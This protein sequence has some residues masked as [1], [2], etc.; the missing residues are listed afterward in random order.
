[1]NPKRLV[2]AGLF[3]VSIATGAVVFAQDSKTDLKM[4]PREESTR[5][6]SVLPGSTTSTTTT[7][8]TAPVVDAQGNPVVNVAGSP[9]SSQTGTQPVSGTVEQRLDNH[10]GRITTLEQPPAPPVAPPLQVCSTSIGGPADL[11]WYSNW[12]DDYRA[13]QFPCWY[14]HLGAVVVMHTVPMCGATGIVGDTWVAFEGFIPPCA[15]LIAAL[16]NGLN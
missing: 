14:A 3:F 5:W 12:Q 2:L 10:E 7:V 1:M 13:E 6:D 15:S 9:Q 11:N 8:P 4:I 16:P